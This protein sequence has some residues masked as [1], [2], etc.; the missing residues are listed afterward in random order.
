MSDRLAV[1]SHGRIAQVGAPREVYETPANA[2]VADFLGVAN[3]LAVD[4]RDGRAHVV[5]TALAFDG[6]PP[7][8]TSAVIRPERI[9]LAPGGPAVVDEVVYAG[10][11]T[12][13][14]LHLG[15]V[16]LQ[17]LVANDGRSVPARGD[18]VAVYVPADAVRYL[19]D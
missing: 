6:A 2:Y 14:R 8:A 12:M 13:V 15:A 1:M 18:A 11:T 19:S 5:G 4:C 7:T 10:A 9:I 17:V 3:L 16:V